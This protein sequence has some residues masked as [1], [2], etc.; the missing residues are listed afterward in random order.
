[1]AMISAIL[2]LASISDLLAQ[3]SSVLTVPSA[4]RDHHLFV[5]AQLYVHQGEERI[6]IEKIR[7][8]RA[9][10]TEPDLDSIPIKQDS[11]ITYRLVPKVSAVVAEITDMSS[12][13]VFTPTMKHLDQQSQLDI[14]FNRQADYLEAEQ[15]RLESEG[16]GASD[17]ADSGSTTDSGAFSS[18]TEGIQ[19]QLDG[20]SDQL[21]DLQIMQ[22]S[23][24]WDPELVAGAE[25]SGGNTA[26]IV[27]NLSSPT[28]IADA[29]VFAAIRISTND[30]LYD[31]SVY[32]HVGEVTPQARR[33]VLQRANLPS[34]FEI[35][36]T[37]VFV[38]SQGTE[39]PTNKS[40]K[41]FQVTREEAWEFARLS[42]L[43]D[44][45]RESVSARPAWAL[46]PAR[47]LGVEA[48]QGISNPV[49]IHLDENGHMTGLV[50]E[51]A[52][53][54]DQVDAIL[55][56]M[57]FLPALENGQPVPSILTVDPADFFADW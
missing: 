35:K 27:L 28:H 5:G 53:V 16:S 37:H 50:D 23:L 18:G 29:Y 56:E 2:V 26:K 36:E 40:E 3:S 25:S 42:H 51:G 20:V 10:V 46:A 7:G 21:S 19:A 22:E 43:G 6:P 14:Y 48:V 44:Y 45:G 17:D 52:I 41:H 32:R 12:E 24:E 55:Q 38:F 49:R 9:L 11:T 57:A 39:I 31:L 47:L 15:R 1:M 34:G 54:P 33:V 8:D 13:V 30:K 4:D